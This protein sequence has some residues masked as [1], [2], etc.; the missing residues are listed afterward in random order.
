MD[1]FLKVTGDGIQL[2]G[3]QKAAILLCELMGT[4]TGENYLANIDLPDD[5]VRKLRMEIQKLGKFNPDN[6]FMVRRENLVLEEALKIG[7]IKGI[8]TP[9]KK[10]TKTE[11]F[12][13]KS[14]IQDLATNNPD[15]I[16]KILSTWINGDE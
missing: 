13:K 7:Q 3:P 1:D 12:L 9:P 2:T 15:S 16:A 6:D 10:E 11:K 4:K 14:G 8:Y 5:Q